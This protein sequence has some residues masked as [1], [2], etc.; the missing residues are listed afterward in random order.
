MQLLY[1]IVH[2]NI[3]LRAKK[4][5]RLVRGKTYPELL[6]QTKQPAGF[7]IL[8]LDRFIGDRAIPL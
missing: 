8:H 7:G 1:T 5:T 6:Y 2:K 3:T 4:Q